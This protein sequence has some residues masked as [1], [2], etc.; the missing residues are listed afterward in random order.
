MD[1]SDGCICN[2]MRSGNNTVKWT[3]PVAVYVHL[4]MEIFI[5]MPTSPSCKKG[6]EVAFSLM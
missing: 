5:L 3:F 6:K 4:D 1:V 2:A